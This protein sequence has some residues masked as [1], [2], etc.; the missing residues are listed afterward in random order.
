LRER[1]RAICTGDRWDALT[2]EV[3][4]QSTD[5]WTAADT[6]LAGVDA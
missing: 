4:A 1:A 3:V 5:P 2:D 6:M